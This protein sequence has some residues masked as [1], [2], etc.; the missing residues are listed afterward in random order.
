MRWIT[1]YV[2]FISLIM[3]GIADVSVRGQELFD[4]D[5]IRRATVFIFQTR[6]IAD[7]VII[8]CVGTGTIVNRDGLILTNAH[9]TVPNG[10]CQGDRVLI[11][12]NTDFDEPPVPMFRATVTQ[13]NPG[14]DLA[15]L[16]ISE[17]SDG[18][19]ITPG[20]L[21]L[22]FVELGD[23]NTLAL[24]STLTMLG[25]PDLGDSPLIVTRSTVVSFLSEPSGSKS[26]VKI[27][28]ALPG[29]S[30]GGGAYDSN[31]R[32][33]AITTTAPQNPETTR[34]NCI[35]LQDTSGNNLIDAR[36]R[37]VPLG[38]PVTT[39]RPAV[40]AQPLL[41]AALFDLDVTT[42]VSGVSLTRASGAPS[43]SRLFFASA[44]NEAGMPS[45]V[46]RTLPTGANAV[47][48]FFNYDNMTSE[49]IYELRVTVNGVPAPTFSLSPVR[50]SSGIRGMWHIGIDGQPL[51]G[52][53]YDFTLLL[54]GVPAD[55]ARLIVGQSPPI[56]R[57]LQRHR[58][59]HRG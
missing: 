15:L 10:V 25:Y 54:D 50:W 41:R 32:L 23:S 58:L 16:R 24:D 59:R 33:V 29:T 9:H 45:S 8:T 56:E 5:R 52:G 30:T 53:V 44:V 2:L 36:D 47:Y 4:L 46:V 37:C 35:V 22:P 43:V 3:L 27:G 42:S 51:P 13:A 1:K 49:T 28:T 31:G 17:H 11:A 12:L 7:R 19:T 38:D 14:L 57:R 40:F 55:T 21:S 48:L 18:R 39:L 34:E 26:W 20:T 6:T